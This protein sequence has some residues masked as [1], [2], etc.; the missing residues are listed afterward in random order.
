MADN[1]PTWMKRLN[2]SQKQLSLVAVLVALGLLLWGRLLMQGV[3]RTATAEGGLS[4]IAQGPEPQADNPLRE[5]PRVEVRLRREIDRDLFAVPED[6]YRKVR[7][8][9]SPPVQKSPPQTSDEEIRAAQMREALKRLRLE[10]T[11]LGQR[12]L[13]LISGRSVR[14]GEKIEGFTLLEVRSRSVI[15]RMHGLTVELEIGL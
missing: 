9:S 1:R 2:M 15:L 4:P 10:S 7:E 11:V 13:A 5:R 3:T 8:I 6:A 14:P 12:P